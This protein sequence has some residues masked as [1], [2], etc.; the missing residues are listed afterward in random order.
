MN[1]IRL[2]NNIVSQQARNELKIKEIEKENTKDAYLIEIE[3]WKNNNTTKKVIRELREKRE[4]LI[5]LVLDASI[6][7]EGENKKVVAATITA[8]TIDGILNSINT[9][10]ILWEKK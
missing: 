9:G 7:G 3:E 5:G 6:N 2:V 8:A 1:P 4:Q 10:E